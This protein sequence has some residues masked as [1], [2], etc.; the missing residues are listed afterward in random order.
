MII[1][2]FFADLL[3]MLQIRVSVERG[4][5]LHGGYFGLHYSNNNIDKKEK[6]VTQTQLLETG[7]SSF[8][9]KHSA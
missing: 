4:H 2:T 5:L 9:R 1:I 3:E 6:W 8:N 7:G